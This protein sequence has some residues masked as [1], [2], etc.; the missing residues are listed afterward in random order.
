MLVLTRK[1]GERLVIGDNITVV[2]TRIAGNRV[3]VG[4][5]APTEVP[6]IRGELDLFA[7]GGEVE[8]SAAVSL[9]SGC[10]PEQ[11]RTFVPRAAR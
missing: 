2:V 11:N 10:V 6:I 5:E 4:I 7:E 9:G 8:Q 3:T 1:V